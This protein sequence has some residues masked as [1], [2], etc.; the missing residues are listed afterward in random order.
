MPTKWDNTYGHQCAGSTQAHD[1]SSMHQ[2]T[3]VSCAALGGGGVEVIRSQSSQRARG[4][5]KTCDRRGSAR[6]AVPG[7][8]VRARRVM[9]GPSW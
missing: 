6:R 5:T 3:L 1:N 7:K 4:G 2:K 9:D 8:Q